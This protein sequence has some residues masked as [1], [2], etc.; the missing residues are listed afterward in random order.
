MCSYLADLGRARARLHNSNFFPAHM[1]PPQGAWPERMSDVVMDAAVR[2]LAAAFD[3]EGDARRGVVVSSLMALLAESEPRVPP[4]GATPFAQSSALARFVIE[5]SDELASGRGGGRVSPRVMFEGV[6]VGEFLGELSRVYAQQ[7]IECM[8][9]ANGLLDYFAQ[10]RHADLL[11][12]TDELQG[13]GG[14]LERFTVSR[15]RETAGYW[16]RADAAARVVQEWWSGF[17]FVYE[18]E[19][20][21]GGIPEEEK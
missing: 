12:A 2:F 7:R 4:R 13:F 11:R 5:V 17:E 16:A 9:A 1:A 8:A 6:S 21:E 3:W 20:V 18:E 15:V 14:E 19:E 10:A